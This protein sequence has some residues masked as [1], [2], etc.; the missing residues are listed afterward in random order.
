MGRVPPFKLTIPEQPEAVL[1]ES[2]ARA[3]DMLLAPP[4]FWFS[5]AIGACQLTAQQAAALSRAGVKRGLPDLLV[6]YERLFGIEL[7]LAKGVLSKTKIV[8]TR[9]GSP[10]VLIGQVERFAELEAAGMRIA[11]CR[12]VDEVLAQLEA[13]GVPLRG[14]VVA[15]RLPRADEIHDP[16]FTGG[17]ES[18]EYV[19]RLRDG[20]LP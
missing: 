15:K 3:L 4:A 12:S 19:R 6:L 16:D 9:R 1:Q 11:I 13:W 5:A 14:R 10:R 7:K 20:T 18:A 2:C 17:L 8:Q